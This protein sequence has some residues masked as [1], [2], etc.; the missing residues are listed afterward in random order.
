MKRELKKILYRVASSTLSLLFAFIVTQL[1]LELMQYVIA[2]AM[3]YHATFTYNEV[4]VPM[5][6]H[7]WNRIRVF[8]LDFIPPT[9]CLFVGL[10]LWMLMSKQEEPWGK[11][12][13]L[14][15][16]LMMCFINI[17]LSN[18]L[19]APIG[20]ADPNSV[21]YETFARLLPW[22]GIPTLLATPLA[23][24]AIL[25]TIGLG[26]FLSV[27]TVKLSYS[28]RLVS[29]N[30]GKNRI[31]I[32]FYMAPV[33]LCVWPLL[34]LTKGMVAM[35]I[36]VILFNLLLFPIGMFLRNSVEPY[37]VKF[38]KMGV[39]RSFPLLELTLAT[40]AWVVIY[41]FYR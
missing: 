23:V 16:W 25:A 9:T 38:K 21:F 28:Q 32:E 37:Q 22:L 36:G 7:L 19:F 6:W 34:L 33:L 20:M 11:L 5:D 39:G 10:Y 3:G 41:L 29:N 18:L 4:T 27:E 1:L 31:I 13:L 24:I 17:F 2:T 8:V 35:R 40:A 15:Y 14:S 30:S 26:Y 12:Q